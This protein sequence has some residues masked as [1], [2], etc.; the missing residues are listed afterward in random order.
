MVF[1]SLLIAQSSWLMCVNSGLGMRQL[2]P[3]EVEAFREALAAG[4]PAT[5]LALDLS[6]QLNKTKLWDPCLY[7][8]VNAGRFDA[9]ETGHRSWPPK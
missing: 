6:P 8:T 4:K 3:Y 7:P 9:Q 2:G 5:R 1:L